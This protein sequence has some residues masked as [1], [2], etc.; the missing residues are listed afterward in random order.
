MGATVASGVKLPLESGEAQIAPY[1]GMSM[2]W[3]TD[4]EEPATA[5]GL[6]LGVDVGF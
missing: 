2:T 5:I 6:S 1:G 4:G 3:L